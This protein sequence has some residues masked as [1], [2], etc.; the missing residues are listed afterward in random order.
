MVS[1]K[2]SELEQALLNLN[3]RLKE[4][5]MTGLANSLR[6]APTPGQALWCAAVRTDPKHCC[7]ICVSDK[8]VRSLL[9]TASLFPEGLHGV[10]R[11]EALQKLPRRQSEEISIPPVMAPTG[12]R[13]DSSPVQLI[14]SKATQ[15][16]LRIAFL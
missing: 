16:R 1:R 3:Q 2:F 7:H 5:L 14:I 9:D 8:G 6:S 12:V 4:I 11:R 15:S 13:R 10:H